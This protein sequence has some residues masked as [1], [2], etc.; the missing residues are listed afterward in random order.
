MS[1]RGESRCISSGT[2]LTTDGRARFGP[3][4][5][6]RHAEKAHV[7][8]TR[9]FQDGEVEEI[10]FVARKILVRTLNKHPEIVQAKLRVVPYDVATVHNPC[11]VALLPRSGGETDKQLLEAWDKGEIQPAKLPEE[12]ESDIV[13]I[14]R[15]VYRE[16]FR[17]PKR[18]GGESR[19]KPRR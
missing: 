2:D 5:S 11:T 16:A 13:E 15:N 18:K 4:G 7:S 9:G 8:A 3:S 1:R 12:I 14:L 6:R 10:D 17:P 19:H